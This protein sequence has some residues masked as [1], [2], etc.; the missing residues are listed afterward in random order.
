[1]T[2]LNITFTFEDAIRSIEQAR[3][4]ESCALPALVFHMQGD[5]INS[6]RHAM[7]H[8]LTVSLDASHLQDSSLGHPYQKWQIITNSDF[9]MLRFC[10]YNLLRYTSRL[11]H[12]TEHR[13]LRNQRLHDEAKKRSNAY[14][15][16]IGLHRVGR[17]SVGYQVLPDEMLSV[18]SIRS[19]PPSMRVIGRGTSS[20]GMQYFR[21]E[22]ADGR[23]FEVPVDRDEAERHTSPLIEEII[24]IKDRNI[25]TRVRADGHREI[26]Q[27]K[28][29][30][31]R[32]GEACREILKAN[33]PFSPFDGL[34]EEYWI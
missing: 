13:T 25:L 19:G 31:R 3:K 29:L 34:N 26:A 12:E 5:V 1:M 14:T 16:P 9:E 17:G 20:C 22:A 27:L 7:D 18:T 4:I 23:E 32:F 2:A 30:H 28:G 15:S 11:W 24:P 33:D 10:T 8:F 6:Y 21:I